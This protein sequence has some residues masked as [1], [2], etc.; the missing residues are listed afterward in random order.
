MNQKRLTFIAILGSVLLLLGALAFQYLGDLPPC[1]LCYWQRYPHIIAIIFGVIYSFTSIGTIVV[2]PAVAAFSSAGV[3]A[4]HFGIEKAFW[5]GPNTCSSGNINN[6][7]TDALIEQIMSA[8]ITKCDEVLWSFLSI[9][10]AGWNTILSAFLGLLWISLFFKFH[11]E[12]S[13][14]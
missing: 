9:S 6:I 11:K 5:P 13:T 10:M 1:K 3:G 7:S 4:Y 2:I 14:N 12:K 8:P